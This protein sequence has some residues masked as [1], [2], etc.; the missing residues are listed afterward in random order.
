MCHRV[1][2][3]QFSQRK[4]GWMDGLV[5]DV[6]YS[7]CHDNSRQGKCGAAERRH[8]SRICRRQHNIKTSSSSIYF[9]QSTL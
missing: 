6:Q 3:V 9:P 8:G 2:D 5:F 1:E 4:T 7:T